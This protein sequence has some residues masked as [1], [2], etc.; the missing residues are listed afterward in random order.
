[1]KKDEEEEREEEEER[2]FWF[3][4]AIKDGASVCVICSFDH[5]LSSSFPVAT[6]LIEIPD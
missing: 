5:N 6:S 2:R 4:G 3:A 1:M